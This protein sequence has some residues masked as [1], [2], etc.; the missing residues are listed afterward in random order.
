M[1]ILL[2]NYLMNIKEE[3]QFIN[4]NLE[5]F[6]FGTQPAN[7]YQPIDY[8]LTLGGKRF[9]PLLTLIGASLYSKNYREH[10]LPALATEVFHNFTLVHDDIM[11]KAPMRRGMVTVHE[12]WNTNIAILSGDV[13]MVKAYE[14][15]SHVE[16]DKLRKS[17]QDFNKCAVEVCEGQQYDM[18]FETRADVQIEEYIEMIRLKTAVLLGFSLSFGAFLGNA[19]EKDVEALKQFGDNIGIGF[20]LQDDLLD[21]FG[22][23]AAVGKTIGGDILQNKKTFLLLKTLELAS[24]TQQKDI[25]H[26]LSMDKEPEQKIAAI[27]AIMSD[28]GIEI[29]TKDLMNTY[30]EKGFNYLN[31]LS[32]SAEKIEFLKTFSYQLIEREK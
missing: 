11:D 19:P 1:G 14:L 12:K 27:K 17:L 9:R 13:M 32:A 24:E 22:K 5:Q 15:L 29:I 18:D 10:I 8:F 23:E 26:W 31:T 2:G 6:N 7:L 16:K 3:I 25:N 30:F 20:Q 21:T 4:A 28:L